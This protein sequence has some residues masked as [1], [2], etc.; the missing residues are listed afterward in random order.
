MGESGNLPFTSVKMLHSNVR[1]QQLFLTY[2][3]HFARQV[4]LRDTQSVTHDHQTNFNIGRHSCQEY[5]CRHWG[6]SSRTQGPSGRLQPLQ[7]GSTFSGSAF[8]ALA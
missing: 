2:V 1:T 4:M 7:G 5:T 8:S 6:P 3:T